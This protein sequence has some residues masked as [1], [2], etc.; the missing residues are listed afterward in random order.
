MAD[1][2]YK[3]YGVEEEEFNRA[4][5]QH[6]I[7]N[8]PEVQRILQES[9]KSMPPEVMNMMM[10]QMMNERGDFEEIAAGGEAV[11]Y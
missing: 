9:L 10:M 3:K 11:F 5:A 4:I 1:K 2:L 8:D 6:N 7:Y